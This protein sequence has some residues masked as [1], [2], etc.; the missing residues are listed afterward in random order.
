MITDKHQLSLWDD[1][2]QCLR[3]QQRWGN[4]KKFGKD[5]IKEYITNCITDVIKSIH[6]PSILDVGCGTGHFLWKFRNICRE[7]TGLDYSQHML[8]ITTDLFK[9]HPE[10][11]LNLIQGSC[12]DLPF[13][14]NEFDIVYQVDV[15]MHIG[16]SWDSILEMIRVS[17]KFVVFTGP[18][19]QRFST[20]TQRNQL[21]DLALNRQSW[22]INNELLDIELNKLIEEKKILN[23]KYEYRPP[24]TIYNHRILVIEKE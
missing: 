5:H 22:A 1:K 18:S 20:K 24:V 2:N 7:M 11:K 15:C 4:Y 10:Y 3:L 13:K 23:F 8:D 6:K 12:W 19:F 14:E 16:G 21:M 17:K 9:D